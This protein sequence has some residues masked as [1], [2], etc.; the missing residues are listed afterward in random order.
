MRYTA[1]LLAFLAAFIYGMTAIMH[2]FYLQKCDI[3][4]LFVLYG[5]VYAIAIFV[6]AAYNISNI[7]ADIKTLSRLHMFGIFVTSF[8]GLL[9]ANYLYLY[10]LKHHQSFAV[11]A[12]ISIAP[13][14]T[15]LFAYIILKEDV[16]LVSVIGVCSIVVGVILVA[17]G[18]KT[19]TIKYIKYIK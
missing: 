11:A 19:A 6:V 8:A 2:K 12:L 9:I 7:R 17:Y 10:L 4:T 14:F 18:S 3:S 5:L 13:L 1:L 16:S 15:L